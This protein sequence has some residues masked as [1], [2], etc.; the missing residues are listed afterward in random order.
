MTPIAK[1]YVLHPSQGTAR[2]QLMDATTAAIRAH[3]RCEAERATENRRRYF[4]SFEW[5]LYLAGAALE[6]LTAD[7]RRELVWQDIAHNAAELA[8]QALEV[9]PGLV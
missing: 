8:R 2:E 4:D 6:E 1:D 5:S 7:G 3:L 9:E